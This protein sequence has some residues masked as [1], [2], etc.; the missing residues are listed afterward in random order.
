MT[1]PSF[2]A[3]RLLVLAA[4]GGAAFGTLAQEDALEYTVSS[5]DTLGTVAKRYLV[6]GVRL[7]ELRRLNSLSSVDLIRPGQRL[8]IPRRLARHALGEAQV[9]TLYCP[10]GGGQASPDGRLRV[11]DRLREG[12]SIE[13]PTPCH[14]ALLLPDQAMVRLAPGSRVLIAQLR[15][16]ALESQHAIRLDVQSGLAETAVQAGRSPRLPLEVRT[17]KAL[18][19]VRGT[20]FRVGYAADSETSMVE[21]LSGRVAAQ[22]SADAT[23]QELSAGFGAV[24][25]ADGVNRGPERLPGAPRLQRVSLDPLASQPA[26]V[27]IEPLEGAARYRVQADPSVTAFGGTELGVY[28]QPRFAAQGLGATATVYR[29]QALAPSGLSGQPADIAVCRDEDPQALPRC[30]V[31]FGLPEPGSQPAR[32]TLE[33]LADAGPPTVLAQLPVS[34][35]AARF[36]ITGLQAGAYRWRA[37]YDFAQAG[38]PADRRTVAGS[39]TLHPV[40]A[41]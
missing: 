36:A 32:F 6:Q 23:A 40:R 17:P 10:P 27:E 9:A 22:G 8:T 28:T 4:L 39:F 18:V 26:S 20:E 14:A 25:A 33:A 41:P 11:G 31:Q 34:A 12:Q 37:V 21:V 38:Q 30:T 2:P 1:T 3:F 13:V 19:G 16:Y 35:G 7:E 15:K 5:G 24:I 29:I